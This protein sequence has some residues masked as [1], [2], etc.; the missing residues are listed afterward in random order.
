M[1]KDFDIFTTECYLCGSVLQKLDICTSINT[2]TILFQGRVC[3]G[4]GR[5]IVMWLL[6][7]LSES[8]P[9]SRDRLFASFNESTQYVAILIKRFN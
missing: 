3:D 8:L 5:G 2:D 1:A 4:V 6:S 7:N 9:H